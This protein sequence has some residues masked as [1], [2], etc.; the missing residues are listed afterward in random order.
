MPSPPPVMLSR[1]EREIMDAI[2]AL[3]DAATAERIREQMSDPPSYSAVRAMLV[4]LEAKGHVR[5]RAD[6]PRYLF[7]PVTPRSAARRTALQQLVRVFFEG[8]AGQTAA[9][10]LKDEKWT[11]E[12]LGTLSREI[13]R[14]RKERKR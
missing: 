1:R 6:G 10:L 8:S 12:E 5:H 13:E 2:F 4:R 11:D 3:G 7:S 9:A 14:V